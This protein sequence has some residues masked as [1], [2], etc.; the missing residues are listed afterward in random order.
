MREFYYGFVFG[1]LVEFLIAQLYK[2]WDKKE[3]ESD[4]EDKLS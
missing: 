4:G 2:H 1:G 3:G